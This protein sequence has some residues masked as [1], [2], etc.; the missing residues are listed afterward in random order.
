M[1]EKT[2]DGTFATVIGNSPDL[3]ALVGK[4]YLELYPNRL[5]IIHADAFEY[6]I[7]KGINYGAVWHD[8][9]EA[10]GANNLPEMHRP[11]RK[12]GRHANWQGS[13]CRWRCEQ[14]RARV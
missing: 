9:W 2:A 13:W 14:Q 4:H 12:Y 8:I 11:H 10:I 1:N 5:E 3:I 7:P 6:K